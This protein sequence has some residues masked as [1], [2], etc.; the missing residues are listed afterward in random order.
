MKLEL[1]NRLQAKDFLKKPTTM[2]YDFLNCEE[3]QGSTGNYNVF[4]L[5]LIDEKGENV[6]ISGLFLRDLQGI[7]KVWGEESDIWNGN[8]E[9]STEKDGQYHKWNISPTGT[10]LKRQEVRP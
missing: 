8:L 9:I 1:Q 7:I 3:K 5:G 2:E 6:K 10:V 4:E